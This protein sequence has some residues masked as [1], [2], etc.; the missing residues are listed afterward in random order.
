M[1][2]FE[3]DQ[4]G[5]ARLSAF[6]PESENDAEAYLAGLQAVSSLEPPFVM[7]V[8]IRGHL[9]LDHEQR[10]RQNLWFKATREQLNSR[11]RAASIVRENPT[12][13]MQRAFGG[14]WTFPLLVTDDESKARAFVMKYWQDRDD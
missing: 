9:H 14:L 1:V 7:L 5:I 11:C 10:K 4:T 6:P 8:S 3:F 13:E 2:E 12:E